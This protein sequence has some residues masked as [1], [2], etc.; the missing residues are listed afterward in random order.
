MYHRIAAV[1]PDPWQLAV[2][3]A[4]FAEHLEVVRRYGRP[5]TVGDLSR[6]VG[7]GRIPPRAIVL[8]L[9]DGYADNLLEARPL[10]ARHDVPA[11]IFI[12]AGCL[13]R[14][15]GFWWDQLERLVLTPVDL[16]RRLGLEVR[17]EIHQYDLAQLPTT[18]SGSRGST[19]GGGRVRISRP[20]VIDRSSP[21]T[22]SSDRSGEAP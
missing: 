8:T 11:T 18:R 2:T 19:P 10:L 14:H 3:P 15:Q 17:G 4:H 12:A 7:A 13:G 5:L 22:G 21:C 1:T 16:P 20:G 6:A 9:D